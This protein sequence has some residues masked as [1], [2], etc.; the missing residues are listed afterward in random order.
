MSAGAR[1]PEEL[2]TLLEDAFVLRDAAA[3]A[4]LFEPAGVL[5]VD[6]LAAARG[7]AQIGGVCTELWDGGRGYVADPRR[8]VTARDVALVMGAGAVHV[9]RRARTGS[10][11]YVITVLDAPPGGSIGDR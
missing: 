6:G 8:V 1:S 3:S 4:R 10:W 11:R 7:R 9:A 2:D 5:V